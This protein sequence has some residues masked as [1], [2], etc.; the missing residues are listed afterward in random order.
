MKRKIIFFMEKLKA[1]AW[2]F[3]FSL[4][5]SIYYM[6]SVRRGKSLNKKKFLESALVAKPKNHGKYL[7]LK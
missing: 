5:Q 3:T 2:Y 4:V 1:L 6:V 7:F